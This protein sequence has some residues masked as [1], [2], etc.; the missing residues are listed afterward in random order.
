MKRQILLALL[1]LSLTF[2]A[3]AGVKEIGT[4]NGLKIFRVKT[5]GLFSPSTTTI[6][7]CDPTKP[8]VVEVLNSVGGP[9]LVPA[10]ATAGGVV[11]GAVLLRPSTTKVN[12]GSNSTATGNGGSSTGGGGNQNGSIHHNN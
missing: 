4:I 10:V 8:G 9:G 12:N 2:S 3:F 5:A 1:G 11:G 7:A 6:I